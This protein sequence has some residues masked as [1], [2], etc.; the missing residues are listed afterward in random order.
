MTS[1]N[2]N[3]GEMPADDLRELE[4][5]ADNTEAVIET[6]EREPERV[7]RD[8]KPEPPQFGNKTD[9]KRQEIFESL[10]KDG[11]G[12]EIDRADETERMMG[13][14]NLQTRADREAAEAAARAEG[15]DE[16]LEA[17]P[18]PRRVKVKVNGEEREYDEEQ[19]IGFAQV[20]LASDD[21]LSQAKLIKQREQQALQAAQERLA[22]VERMMADHSQTAQPQPASA[23]QVAEDTK[24][25]TDDELDEIIERIQTGSL[26]EG[27]EALN[28][29]GA[30]V[31]AKARAD[32]GDIK[33]IVAAT[34]RQEQED[35]RVK[36]DTETVI[37]EFIS[38]NSDFADSA[39]R[40]RVLADELEGVMRENLHALNVP[41]EMIDQISRKFNLPP[42]A[43]VG[44][45]TRYLR[46]IGYELPDG[47]SAMR[48]AAARV[49]QTFGMPDPRTPAPPARQDHTQSAV[50]E[51]IAR[52]QAMAPQPQRANI[53]PGLDTAPAKSKDDLNREWLRQAKYSRRGR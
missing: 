43:A 26:E 13:G 11:R 53:A 38:E 31:L 45:A 28:K 17:M 30:Q 35:A 4:T 24:P 41:D 1:M 42:K 15:A 36:A 21:I 27:A 19:V 6:R 44:A 46:S 25:A 37:N 10:R 22:A 49:R 12:A 48:T 50:A 39:T 23:R 3:T 20:A 8:D 32:V 7:E 18:A 2:E 9:R 29:F 16:S 47:A 5:P 51:R 40:Q 52:K 34:I 14:H 33:S